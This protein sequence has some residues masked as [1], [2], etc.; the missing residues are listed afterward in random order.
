MRLGISLAGPSLCPVDPR[1]GSVCA[2]QITPQGKP[3][4]WS[5]CK[6]TA[7]SFDFWKGQMKWKH[8]PILII[9]SLMFIYSFEV[10]S[11]YSNIHNKC[12]IRWARGNSLGNPWS[13]HILIT[14]ISYGFRIRV[15]HGTINSRLLWHTTLWVRALFPH[16]IHSSNSNHTSAAKNHLNHYD[17]LKISACNLILTDDYVLHAHE[18]AYSPILLHAKFCL[19]GIN[20]ILYV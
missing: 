5:W 15:V 10:H 1:L 13:L 17:R 12:I 2:L 11:V 16:Q 7:V 6:S 4:H 3:A 20:S 9:A 8:L 19:S 18:Y 14:N